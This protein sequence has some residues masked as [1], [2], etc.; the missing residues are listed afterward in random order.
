MPIPLPMLLV[1]TDCYKSY[2]NHS[3]VKDFT[4]WVF[5]HPTGDGD[6]DTHLDFEDLETAYNLRMFTKQTDEYKSLVKA[7][8]ELTKPTCVFRE[9]TPSGSKL[10]E[11]AG[12][13]GHRVVEFEETEVLPD[14]NEYFGKRAKRLNET[15]EVVEICY[16]WWNLINRETEEIYFK[17]EKNNLLGIKF[18]IGH[19]TKGTVVTA[20]LPNGSKEEPSE[21]T[22]DE[23]SC[24]GTNS[25]IVKSK[26]IRTEGYFKGEA[27][28]FNVS[29]VAGIVK[30][31][32]APIPFEEKAGS[33]NPYKQIRRDFT[34]S[35][36]Y[37]HECADIL[38]DIRVKKNEVFVPSGYDSLAGIQRLASDL[39]D[40]QTRGISVDCDKLM[41]RLISMGLAR[42]VGI[43][44][45]KRFRRSLGYLVKDKE[46]RKFIQKNP[47]FALITP[48]HSS[49]LQ[50]VDGMRESRDMDRMFAHDY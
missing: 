42:E 3:L 32:N 31:P 29:Y 38:R 19:L 1:G 15:G 21:Y 17:K 43:V 24:I 46:A 36:Y 33:R 11:F 47:Q 41:K 12:T 23:V 50:R 28:T 44:K 10:R 18:G 22:V 34:Q 7:H 16:S 5:I 49:V 9:V 39:T 27:H 48:H 37:I 13:N 35:A 6:L 30:R 25:W 40:L 45:T 2:M 4:G 20:S 8:R 14:G 26:E